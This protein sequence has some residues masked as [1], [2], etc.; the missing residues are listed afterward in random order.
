MSSAPSSGGTTE[1]SNPVLGNGSV[2]TFPRVGPCYESG[3]VI[4]NRDGVFCGVHAEELTWKQQALR[5]S[6]F[7]VV[8]SNG[9]FVLEEELEVD[10]WRLK[11]WLKSLCVL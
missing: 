10:L 9:K 4:N 3:E 11:V 2:N 7:S 8:D 6:H 5:V 1:F